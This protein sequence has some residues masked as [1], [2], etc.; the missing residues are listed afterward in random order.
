MIIFD[1]EF[2]KGKLRTK[3]LNPDEAKETNNNLY[4]DIYFKDLSFLDEPEYLRELDYKERT[5]GLN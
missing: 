5:K 1:Q 4:E 2:I 3:I